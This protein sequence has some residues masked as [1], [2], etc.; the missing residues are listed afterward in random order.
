M[1]LVAATSLD[2]TVVEHAATIAEL[3]VDVT[4]TEIKLKDALTKPRLSLATQ[5]GL[6]VSIRSRK[7]RVNRV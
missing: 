2:R 1:R 7:S 5:D 3:K 6:T 4:A